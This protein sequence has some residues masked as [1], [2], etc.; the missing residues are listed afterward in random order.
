MPD[1]ERRVGKS[2]RYAMRRSLTKLEIVKKKP[3]IDRVFLNGRKFSCQ[4]VKMIVSR[5]DQEIDR[6]VVIPVRHFGTSVQR[7]RIRRQIKEIWRL[8]KHRFITGFDFA[9]VVYPGKAIEHD[10]QKQQL[11]ALFEQAKVYLPT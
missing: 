5:N 8:E 9:F 10:K 1:E 7:N 11:I 4:G 3:E 2:S 6:I